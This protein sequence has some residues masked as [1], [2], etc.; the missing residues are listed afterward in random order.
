MTQRLFTLL[1]GLLICGTTYAARPRLAVVG[2]T[3][4]HRD[5]RLAKGHERLRDNL[6]AA[7]L[8]CGRFEI[9]ERSRLEALLSEKNLA[10]EGLI[11]DPL[12]A[13][14][15]L[16]GAE[17]DYLVMGSLEGDSEATK[18][19][20]KFVR[21]SPPGTGTVTHVFEAVGVTVPY[22][23]YLAYELAQRAQEAFPLVGKAFR[24]KGDEVIIDIGANDGVRGD[25]EF[26]VLHV[27][28]TPGDPYRE[29]T[30]V[31]KLRV[32]DM[33]DRGCRTEV[34]ETLRK[35]IPLVAGLLVVSSRP[36]RQDGRGAVHRRL[37]VSAPRTVAPA[38]PEAD[39]PWFASALATELTNRQSALDAQVLE[40]EHLEALYEEFRLSEL[41]VFNWEQAAKAGN[42]FS[43]NML[44]T[45]TLSKPKDGYEV[46]VRVDDLEHGRVLQGV[47]RNGK[48]L[49]ELA[50][51]VAQA[52]T[53][54]LR[55]P[56]LRAVGDRGLAAAV[57]FNYD[58]VPSGQYA[59]LPRAADLVTVRLENKGAQAMRLR[60][61]TEVAGYCTRPLVREI[62]LDPGST[63]EIGFTPPL[64][65][66]KIASLGDNVKTTVQCRIDSLTGEESKLLEDS[67]EITL[68]PPS[69][70]LARMRLRN[71]S[72]PLDDYAT[73]VAW[74]EQS[75]P[76]TG[77]RARAAQL[78][79]IGGLLGYQ[80]NFLK[81]GEAATE[82]SLRQQWRE[83]IQKQVKAVYKALQEHRIKYADQPVIT[84]PADAGQ[85]V[86]RPAE[87]LAHPGANCLDGSVLFA[88]ALFPTLRPILIITGSHAFV[89]W[90]TWSHPTAPWDVLETTQ[91]GTGDFDTALEQGRKAAERAGILDLLEGRDP[92]GKLEFSDTGLPTVAAPNG[93]VLIDVRLA[94]QFY[95][96]YRNPDWE[97]TSNL[98]RGILAPSK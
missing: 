46:N 73:I 51:Q 30:D 69:T 17:L 90:Q 29:T 21:V 7:L 43:A 76:L 89:G 52:L 3:N 67:H 12:G 84:F 98:I 64:D 78:C 20:A 71:L 6:E 8:Q 36:A 18:A 34:V 91:L 88:A 31:A 37:A 59:Y 39:G 74:V 53:E 87:V 96:S 40:R 66:E 38:S 48:D 70:W 93:A 49:T 80:P 47:R 56:A 85:R 57:Q 9:V 2:F 44:V 62:R 15:G 63:N 26:V 14:A 75:D 97:D 1:I 25:Q 77:V 35:D 19:I 72:E 83:Y 95:E 23:G 4:T 33:Q 54:L 58:V 81:L 55:P 41:P 68:L 27:E 50:S 5:E 65:R 16:Q 45:S 24:V 86:M 28:G 92:A 42:L 10:R 32:I 11:A 13:I 60:V 22:V 79:E 94:R 82:G 61:A